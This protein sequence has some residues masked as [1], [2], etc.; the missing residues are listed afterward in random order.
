ETLS[1]KENWGGALWWLNS[2]SE[3][4]VNNA[5]LLGAF[6]LLIIG[7]VTWS[8]PNLTGNVRKHILDKIMP[9]SIYRDVLGVGF[10]L[11]FSA[12][13]RAQVTTQ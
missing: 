9:W 2:I 4:F 11:N 7:F 10:L 5:L 1:G 12:L 3:F 6:I 8:M 13:M